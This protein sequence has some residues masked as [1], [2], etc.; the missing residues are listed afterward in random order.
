MKYWKKEYQF[1]GSITAVSFTDST[2]CQVMDSSSSIEVLNYKGD[3]KWCKDHYTAE[4]DWVEIEKGE[5]LLIKSL[6]IQKL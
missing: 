1:I 6:A 2:Y 3:Y 4:R 5:F